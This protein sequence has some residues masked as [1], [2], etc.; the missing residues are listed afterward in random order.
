MTKISVLS[1]LI[2][3]APRREFASVDAAVEFERIKAALNEEA[4]ENWGD[5]AW[6]REQAALLIENLDYGF[7]NDNI[8]SSYFPTSFVGEFE[9]IIIRETRGMKVF[10]TARNGQID[11]SQL[12]NEEWEFPRETLGWHVSEFEDNLVANYADTMERL[13]TVAKLRE[14]TEVNR[15]IFTVMQAAIPSTS[16]FYEDAS[17][18][19]LTAAVLNPL[20][21]EVADTPPAS[22]GG[23]I[24]QGV[25]IVGRAAAIDA[26]SGYTGFA[27]NAL[28]EIRLKGRLGIYRGANI[29]R[30]TNWVDENGVSFIPANE[31]FILG[32][33]VG[34]FVGYGGPKVKQWTEDATDY[35]HF[36]SRRD[37]GCA[38]WHPENARRVK[39]AA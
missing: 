12:S 39:V 8:F 26:I 9:K 18:T 6:H 1:E 36:R 17:A 7:Q 4:K 32:G 27:P 35:T 30:L 16:P 22:G 31:V 11:E 23:S 15:R 29:V 5:V 38:V 37:V 13:I 33:S 19:G 24:L 28:E 2:T 14:Q 34:R 25:S 10:W 20:I 21:S 3:S